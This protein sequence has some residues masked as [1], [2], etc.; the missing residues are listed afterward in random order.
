MRISNSKYIYWGKEDASE[1]DA[2]RQDIIHRIYLGDRQVWEKPEEDI[3]EITDL[4]NS[5]TTTWKIVKDLFSFRV[6]K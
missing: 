6:K 3:T 5:I 2:S 1:E 4:S